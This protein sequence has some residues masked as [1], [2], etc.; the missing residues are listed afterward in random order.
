[1]AILAPPQ[2]RKTLIGIGFPL[3]RP[4]L[5]DDAALRR[6]IRDFQWS[7]GLKVDGVWGERTQLAAYF[8]GLDGGRI[9]EHFTFREFACRCWERGHHGAKFCHGWPKVD[10]RLVVGLEELRRANGGPISIVNGY[11]CPAY[12]RQVGGARLSQHQ[13]GKAA[14]VSQRLTLKPVRALQ[15]FR[16]IGYRRVGGLVL[17]VDVRSGPSLANPTTWVYG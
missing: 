13:K 3:D 5:G 16:G 17:H 12:N 6:A 15:V 11:R 10:R 8:C 9:T 14:D 4:G 7:L 1:M 2:Q